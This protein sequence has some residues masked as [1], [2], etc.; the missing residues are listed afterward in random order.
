MVATPVGRD[1]KITEQSFVDVTHGP[2]P[3]SRCQTRLDTSTSPNNRPCTARPDSTSFTVSQPSRRV[4]RTSLLPFNRRRPFEI[5]ATSSNHDSHSP[6]PYRSSAVQIARAG[7]G[8]VQFRH[9][10]DKA[11]VQHR[12]RN[13]LARPS[14]TRSAANGTQ[15]FHQRTGRRAGQRFRNMP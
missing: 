8:C 10:G 3:P 2:R 12:H 7:C 11:R 4:L 13:P 14:P 9:G 1:C 5:P 6:R 15:P